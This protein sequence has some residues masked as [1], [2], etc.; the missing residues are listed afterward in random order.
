MLTYDT[1]NS[2]IVPMLNGIVKKGS[3]NIVHI[4]F[5][6][7]DYRVQCDLLLY[8]SSNYVAV[9]GRIGTNAFT[10]LAYHDSCWRHDGVA[11]FL[12]VNMEQIESVFFLRTFELKDNQ[13]D[14]IRQFISDGHGTK[15]ELSFII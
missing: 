8:A 11:E 1:I 15:K 7:K 10:L 9:F 5:S 6:T 14:E 13:H 2:F 12:K 3:R 4:T